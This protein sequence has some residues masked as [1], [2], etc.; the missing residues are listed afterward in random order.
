M[1]SRAIINYAPSPPT[2]PRLRKKGARKARGAIIQISA[3]Q[4]PQPLRQPRNELPRG[5]GPSLRRASLKPRRYEAIFTT[6]Q[7]A[8]RFF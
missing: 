8:V 5:R 1:A 4:S 3:E 2:P 7:P 6:S